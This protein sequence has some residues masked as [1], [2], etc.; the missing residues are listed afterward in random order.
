MPGP[1]M[2]GDEQDLPLEF[3]RVAVVENAGREDALN[4][5][6]GPEPPVLLDGKSSGVEQEADPQ[7]VDLPTWLSISS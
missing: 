7:D 4:L 2:S 5:L 3:A 6:D 1:E